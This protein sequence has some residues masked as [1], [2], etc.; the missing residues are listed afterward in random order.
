[1]SAEIPGEISNKDWRIGCSCK[2]KY[3][4]DELWYERGRIID[5][6]PSGTAGLE[7]KDGILK[8]KMD[9]TDRVILRR[10]DEWVTA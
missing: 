8:I 3:R 9:S 2:P 10:A 1:M 5:V 6:L 4:H 7:D